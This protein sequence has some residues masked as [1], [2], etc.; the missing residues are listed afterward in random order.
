VNGRAFCDQDGVVRD[1]GGYVSPAQVVRDAQNSTPGAPARGAV[2]GS[3]R[4]DEFT[5]GDEVKR[6]K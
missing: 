4:F 2:A 5:R 6:G 3:V 1:V